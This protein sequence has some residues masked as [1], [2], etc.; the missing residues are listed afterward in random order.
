MTMQAYLYCFFIRPSF[1]VIRS[2]CI[3][4]LHSTMYGT[5][6]H[7][8]VYTQ[9]LLNDRVSHCPHRLPCQ[10]LIFLNH[11]PY[12][13]CI[14]LNPSVRAS[15]VRIAFLLLSAFIQ[16]RAYRLQLATIDDV[17]WQAL[18]ISATASVASEAAAAAAPCLRRL[19]TLPPPPPCPPP[20]TTPSASLLFLCARY[21]NCAQS[22]VLNI[23]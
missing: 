2:H 21:S 10:P 16:R 15:V 11:I 20:P 18:P 5:R 6:V 7:M 19:T 14:Y 1:S 13:P 23:L 22:R 9:V 12:I 3:H 8:R 17:L 4:S